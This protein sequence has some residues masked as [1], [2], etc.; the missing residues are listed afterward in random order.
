ME[1]GADGVPELREKHVDQVICRQYAMPESIDPAADWEVEEIPADHPD[2]T[3]IPSHQNGVMPLSSLPGSLAVVYL[4]FDGEEGP[5]SG[6]ANIDAA[7]FN[8]SNAQIKDLW[9]RT[10]E[11]FAPFNI[12]VTTDLQVYLD[13]P[14]SNASSIR[15]PHNRTP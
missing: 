5:H 1:L 4:D 14:V 12:N 6:W 15:G 8:L 7:S 2:V 13:A 9:A 11:E 10:A 3:N